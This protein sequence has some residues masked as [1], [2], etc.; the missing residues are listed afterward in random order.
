MYI[1]ICQGVYVCMGTVLQ[2]A[3]SSNERLRAVIGPGDVWLHGGAAAIRVKRKS[4]DNVEYL[5]V[6]HTKE[7]DTERYTTFAYTFDGEP[8]FAISSW[9]LPLGLRGRIQVSLSLSLSLSLSS[10]LSFSLSFSH[11]LIVN[12][13][14]SVSLSL[15]LS[16]SRARALS[17]SLS[18]SDPLGGQPR[19]LCLSR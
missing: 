10:P 17:L 19:W 12:K 3:T 1:R 6:C 2:V 8:P 14:L 16:L 15:C 7:P 9:S 4:R 13:L 18:V 11:L 5:S